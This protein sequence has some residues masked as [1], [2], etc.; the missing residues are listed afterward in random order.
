V[1][2]AKEGKSPAEV[3]KGA[4]HEQLVLMVVGTT[5]QKKGKENGRKWE[6]H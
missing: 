2:N 4:L 1:E 3:R 5:H 6:G